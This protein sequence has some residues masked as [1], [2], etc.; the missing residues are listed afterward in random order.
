MARWRIQTLAHDSPSVLEAALA[1]AANLGFGIAQVDRA[2]GRCLLEMPRPLGAPA[3][4]VEAAV[5][6]NGLGSTSLRVSWDL[7]ATAPWLPPTPRHRVNRLQ[8]LTRLYLRG[9]EFD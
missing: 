5:L 7:P 8:H 4:P 2:T 1:A 3:W 6:D 9:G